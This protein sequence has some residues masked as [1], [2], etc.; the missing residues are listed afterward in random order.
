MRVE[1]GEGVRGEEGEGGGRH[2]EGGGTVEWKISLIRMT[3]LRSTTLGL[4]CFHFENGLS[5]WIHRSD[6]GSIAVQHG[7]IIVPRTPSRAPLPRWPCPVYSTT[8]SMS[9][10]GGCL[11]PF[12][13]YKA[14]N[15]IVPIF[16]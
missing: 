3:Q 15:L 1:E 14:E 10:A 12:L 2:G 7:V 8:S 13:L 16:Y 11:F 5:A 6:G 9:S 4:F